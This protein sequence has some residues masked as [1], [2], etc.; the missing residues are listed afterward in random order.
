MR[1]KINKDKPVFEVPKEILELEESFRKQRATKELADKLAKQKS[2]AEEKRLR[3]ARLK[4]GLKYAKKIFLW[5]EALRKSAGGQELMKKAHIPTVY[6][7]I[8]FFDGHIIGT[9]VGIGISPDGL[10]ITR[11]G[12]RTFHNQQISSPK[13]LA[14][15][16]DTM[17]LLAAC[18]W[19][20]NGEVWNC[21][22]R[23]FSY[24][25]KK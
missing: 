2:D 4:T 20:D 24:L 21:I 17:I 1:K 11:G 18:R 3:A 23:R 12:G 15:S 5:A 9:W 10:F 6:Q 13:E 14:K 22:K 19:I 7:T 16:V 25:N 8:T